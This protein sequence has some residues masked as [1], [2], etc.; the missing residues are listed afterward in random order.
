MP[1]S[2]YGG[3]YMDITTLDFQ[4]A[5]IKQ[6]L[7]KSQ[8]RSVLYGV[9]EPTPGLFSPQENALAQWINAV[10]KPQH[11]NRPEMRQIEQL[12]GHMLETGRI[13]VAQYQRGQIEEARQGLGQIDR[14][15]EQILTLL[16]QLPQSASAA[17]RV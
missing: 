3:V 14:V 11:S 10:V 15:A 17:A 9:R 2:R 6:I 1:S 8:L 12:L 16:Q 13:L 4:Q 5:R 7:F